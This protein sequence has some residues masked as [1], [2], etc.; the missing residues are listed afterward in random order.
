M[1]PEQLFLFFVSRLQSFASL[2][3]ALSC[4]QI[5]IHPATANFAN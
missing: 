4:I 5:Q 3:V 1:S 2:V